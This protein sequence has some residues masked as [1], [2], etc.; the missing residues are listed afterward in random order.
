MRAVQPSFAILAAIV[1]SFP[2][3]THLLFGV[4]IDTLILQLG[5]V[6]GYSYLILDIV[7]IFRLHGLMWHS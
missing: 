6:N 4:E 5:H 7:L 3:R 2:H 1:I